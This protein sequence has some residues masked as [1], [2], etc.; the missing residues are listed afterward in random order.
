MRNRVANSTGGVLICRD[1]R[2]AGTKEDVGGCE[3]DRGTRQ[4]A[5]PA[6]SILS[7]YLFSFCAISKW[8]S[9]AGS[10][11]AA[12]SLSPASVPLLP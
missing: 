12:Q 4:H 8:C 7:G 2:E 1:S 11:V 9:S 3:R 5:P 6:T 10:V